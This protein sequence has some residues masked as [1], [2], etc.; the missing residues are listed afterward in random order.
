MKGTNIP[1][2]KLII[3]IL[4]TTFFGFSILNSISRDIF[5]FQAM[6]FMLGSILFYFYSRF[7]YLNHRSFSNIYLLAS[8][9]FLTLPL[10]F[11]VTTRGSVRWIKIG[12]LTLQP[13]EIIKPFLIVVFANFLSK[14]ESSLTFKNLTTYL[15]ILAIPALLIFKQPD[16]GSTLVVSVIWLGIFISSNLPI[17]WLISI[18]SGFAILSPLVFKLLKSYQ[19]Q[20]ITSFLNPYLDPQGS[21][22]Q[23]IQS[24][25]A[26]GSGGFFGKGFGSGTQS[27]LAFLPEQHSDF[28]FASLAEETGFVGSFILIMGMFFILKR[29]LEIAKF[30]PDKFS[31]YTCIGVFSMILFQSF[32]N[33][34]MNLGVMPITGIT[35]PL[36][37]AGGSSILATMIALGMVHNISFYSESKKSL[38]IR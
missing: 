31:Y 37:S 33:I 2:W 10:I 23:L 15:I 6:S 7:N 35:L 16:L 19:K 30:A 9:I 11:G 24:I 29:I 12:S 13:S 14:F 8:I 22:Y 5:I 1:D 17:L 32:V 21:G 34:G 18:F 38:E 36:V 3:P 28:I 25:I 20:R 4:V 26:V 27:Q